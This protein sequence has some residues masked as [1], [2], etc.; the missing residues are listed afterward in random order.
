MR[1][2]FHPQA[3]SR[4]SNPE[5]RNPALIHVITVQGGVPPDLGFPVKVKSHPVYLHLLHLHL[6]YL[7]R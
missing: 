3:R 4:K 1:K 7:V 6:L 5:M 2:R